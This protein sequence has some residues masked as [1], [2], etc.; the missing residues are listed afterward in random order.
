M[1][2]TGHMRQIVQS[3]FPATREEAVDLWHNIRPIK[4]GQNLAW[5]V[6][7]G[8]SVLARYQVP[9]D[10]AY[11]LILKTECYVFTDQTTAANR[12][13]QAPPMDTAQWVSGVGAT[14]TGIT[15][16][17]P[18]HLLAEASEFLLIKSGALVSLIAQLSARPDLGLLIRTLVYAYHINAVIADRVGSGE[19]LVFGSDISLVP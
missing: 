10:A 11:L 3:C 19:C 7:G 5:P 15:G 12:L 14:A 4:F 2:I 13:F 18:L 16:L 1:I 9:E 6:A 17:V 8:A